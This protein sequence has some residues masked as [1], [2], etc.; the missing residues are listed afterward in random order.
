MSTRQRPADRGRRIARRAVAEL[1][2][3]LRA[4][5]LELGLSRVDVAL[6]AG[7]SRAKLGR[8]ER[9]EVIAP[10]SADLWAIAAAVL[11]LDLRW[12]A[13]PGGEPVR[14]HVQLRLLEAFRRRLDPTVAW[15]TEVPLPIEGDRR[16]WDAVVVATDGWT[17]IEGISRLGAVDAIVRRALLKLR[18]DPRIARLVLLVAATDRNRAA[19][20]T[21]AAVIR[22]DFPLDTRTVLAALAAG[23]TPPPNGIVIVRVSAAVA[24]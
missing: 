8:L 14:D 3:E 6:A 2:A 19:L 10:A 20:D 9:N 24:A 7:V 18:D 13:Y 23:R 12:N 15:R 16:A 4:R 5:R 1:S 22:P 17:A 11:G 21:A